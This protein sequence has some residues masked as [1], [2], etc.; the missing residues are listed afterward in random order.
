MLDQ[1]LEI[2]D[3]RPD[4]DLN[5]MQPNQTLPT[6]TAN[7]INGLDRVMLEAKPDWVLVQGDT[8]LAMAAGLVAF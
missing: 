6:L 5:V 7:L 3:I 8:T 2:F 4:Y 1:V